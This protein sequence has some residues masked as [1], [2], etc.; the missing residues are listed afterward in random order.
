MFIILEYTYILKTWNYKGK[1]RC[2]R[3]EDSKRSQSRV[4]VGVQFPYRES[5]AAAHTHT[6]I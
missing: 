3:N 5:I 1:S 4:E 6:Q 2:R